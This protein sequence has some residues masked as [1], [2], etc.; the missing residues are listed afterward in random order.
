MLE[1]SKKYSY[2]AAAF[3]TVVV[4]TDLYKM[5]VTSLM[6]GKKNSENFFVSFFKNYIWWDRKV[7]DFYKNITLY[8]TVM[9]FLI[10]LIALALFCRSRLFLLIDYILVLIAFVFSFI[11]WLALDNNMKKV[12]TD[13]ID[14]YKVAMILFAFG[15]S[16]LVAL[17]L[18]VST[19]GLM[20]KSR[21]AIVFSVLALLSAFVRLVF[22]VLMDIVPIYKDDADAFF[23]KLVLNEN[24]AKNAGMSFQGTTN[25]IVNV[26]FLFA[27]MLFT[28]HRVREMNAIVNPS[29]ANNTAPV[30]GAAPFY[31]NNPPF[32]GVNQNPAPAQPYQPAFAYQQ[33]VQNVQP[34]PVPAPVPVPA[35]APVAEPVQVIP[36]TIDLNPGE[37]MYTAEEAVE[38]S[39]ETAA[40]QTEAA[41]DA[42]ADNTEAVVEN[43]AEAVTDV[44]ETATDAVEAAADAVSD[45]AE[46]VL[47][48]AETGI[49]EIK[50]DVD[51]AE[52]AKLAE[53]AKMY[54]DM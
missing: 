28:V 11:N 14:G 27:F 21:L 10:L 49:K 46:I 9:L 8:N 54:E 39:A 40:E 23:K 38:K 17:F 15:A 24:S 1:K 50:D 26:A 30:V 47:D 41:V 5:V 31:A 7:D 37:V 12:W 6:Y 36:E 4:L 34:A 2:A 32:P 43:A 20:T 18:I 53:L 13:K 19:I 29:V 22:S 42:V 51:P 33:P 3:L 44:A 35:P 25:D 16:I 48:E 45:S 52:A